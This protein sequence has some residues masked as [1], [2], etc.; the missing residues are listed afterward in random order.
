ME[1]LNALYAATGFDF[2][3]FQ[4]DPAPSN[5]PLSHLQST[6]DKLIW[7]KGYAR[8]GLVPRVV[9]RLSV[10]MKHIST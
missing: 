6:M 2:A 4:E 1:K 7:S 5:N 3:K 8:S 10:M 9:I